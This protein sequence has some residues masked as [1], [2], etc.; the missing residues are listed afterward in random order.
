MGKLAP[1][2][3]GLGRPGE[4]RSRA[5]PPFRYSDRQCSFGAEAAPR[6]R[7]AG[8]AQ[9]SG[10]RSAR[11][12]AWA[13]RSLARDTPATVT[14]WKRARSSLQVTGVCDAWHIARKE[15]FPTV[16]D[17]RRTGLNEAWEGGRF[18]MAPP[19]LKGGGMWVYRLLLRP[20]PIRRTVS[21]R[22]KD[23]TRGFPS[24]T[25]GSAAGNTSRGIGSGPARPPDEGQ[26]ALRRDVRSHV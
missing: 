24:T 4:P 22:R 16:P 14:V 13:C 6:S 26:A 25:R 12:R 21:A 7:I 17:R 11:K 19:T 23:V 20:R 18:L 3:R 10:A 15:D 2:T 1:L 9:R 8:S 5:R